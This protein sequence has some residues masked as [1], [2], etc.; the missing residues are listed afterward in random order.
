MRGHS[1]SLVKLVVTCFLAVIV[2]AP[3]YAAGKEVLTLDQA[4][5]IATG[6]NRVLRNAQIEVG[7]AQSVAAVTRTKG[8]PQLFVTAEGSQLL[9]PVHFDFK[10]GVFGN[11]PVIGQV[12]LAD[13]TITAP[14]NFSVIANATLLQPVTQLHRINL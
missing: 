4:V 10:Q 8:L 12:P 6:N 2:T 14:E 5:S 3:G 7:K 11:Y 1:I 9:A 13:T